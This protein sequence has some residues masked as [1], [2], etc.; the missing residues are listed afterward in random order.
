MK[1]K[2]RMFRKLTIIKVK[3]RIFRNLTTVA[4][5]KQLVMY[6]DIITN[7]LSGAIAGSIADLSTHPLSSE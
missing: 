7:L 2:L 6:Q 5:S 1:V 4:K 3:L